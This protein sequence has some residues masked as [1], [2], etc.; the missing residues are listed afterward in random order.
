M[1]LACLLPCVLAFCAAPATQPAGGVRAN[2][3]FAMDTA[4]RDAAHQTIESQV[5]L[6]KE[7]GYDGWGPSG[8]E[9]VPEMLKALDTAGLK[10]FALYIGVN[11]DAQGASQA[12]ETSAPPA[13]DPKLPPAYDPKLKETIAALKGRDAILWVYLTSQRYKP[14]STDGD[15]RAVHVLREIADL[16]HEAEVQVSIYPHVYNY[17]ER[18]DDAIRLAKKV[19]RRNLGVTFNLCHWLKV[20]GPQD[21]EP[22]LRRAMPYLNVVNINGA[23]RE[24]K[25]WDRLIQPLGRGDYDVYGL[26][27]TLRRL[28]YAGPVGFQ[29]YGIQGD[30]RELL[31][32]TMDAWRDY[33]QRLPE[34]VKIRDRTAWRA[35]AGDRPIRRR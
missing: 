20:E 30:R 13:H 23:D 29:G 16:A 25:D 14:S 32:T 31:K 22:L 34:K 26:L 3:F 7:L 35:P 24:G 15:E 19:N 27:K 4:T 18:T 21:P 6:L 8:T 28:G 2:A 9:N 11:I 17:V 10:L 33:C 5:K 12:G 1:S